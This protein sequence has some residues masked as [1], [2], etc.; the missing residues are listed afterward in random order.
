MVLEST[1]KKSLSETLIGRDR[2]M[3]RRFSLAAVVALAT[4]YSLFSLLAWEVIDGSGIAVIGIWSF[5]GGWT[6]G[7]PIYYAYKYDGALVSWLLAS[8]GPF[9]VGIVLAVSPALTG[10]QTN[11]IDVLGFA[12][13]LSLDFGL[14]VGAIGFAIGSWG[15]IVRDPSEKAAGDQT[16]NRN[17]ILTGMAFLMAIPITQLGLNGPD[18]FLSLQLNIV[19]LAISVGG[20]AIGLILLFRQ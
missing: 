19:L 10:V 20:S 18:G 7:T 13:E 8:V 15:R 2:T 17:A 5:L 9:A 1:P 12:V 6:I 14:P 3:V 16:R 4:F 11:P